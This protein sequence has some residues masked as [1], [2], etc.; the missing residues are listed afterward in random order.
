MKFTDPIEDD[1][2]PRW[3]D[4]PRASEFGPQGAALILELQRLRHAFDDEIQRPR[5]PRGAPRSTAKT[6]TGAS[7]IWCARCSAPRNPR[8]VSPRDPVGALRISSRRE[9]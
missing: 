7:W 4:D 3:S 6:Q 9:P 2:A 1:D 5:K 8:G